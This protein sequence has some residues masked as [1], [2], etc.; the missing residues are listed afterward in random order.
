[1]A[2]SDLGFGELSERVYRMLIDEPAVDRPRLAELLGSVEEQVRDALGGLV[3]LGVAKEDESCPAGVAL[4]RP[5]A[6]LGE[7]IERVE[8]DLLRRQRRVGDTRAEL[9]D[10]SARFERR[11][12]Q[13]ATTAPIERL[14]SLEAVREALQELSFF[15]R[16]SVFSVQPGGPLSAEALAASRPLDLRGLRRGIDMRVIYDVTVLEDELNRNYLREMESAGAKFRVTDQTLERMIIMD[17]RV[18]VVPIDPLCSQRGALVVRQ[19]GLL[20]GFLQLYQR[21][22]DDAEP[23]PWSDQDSGPKPELTETDLQVLRLLASG[24]TDEAA[25]RVVGV[26]VRHLRRRVAKLMDQLGAASR[27]EAG[28]E[29]AHR[30]W[31]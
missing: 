28:V 1:M 2:L 18:A 10:L 9:A 20:M 4:T 15:T 17:E 14:D 31:I 25:S 13:D 21:L 5:A 8:D 22:W 11:P 16:T 24:S 12:P 6:A 19:P 29:A 27:F 30:G 7:L 23:V 3:D 26:S